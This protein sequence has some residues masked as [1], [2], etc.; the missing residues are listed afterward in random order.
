MGN[1]ITFATKYRPKKLTEY[2][3]NDRVINSLLATLR[4]NRPQVILIGG[5][6]G[7]GKTTLA[8][9]IAKEYL[10]EDRDEI[11]G[12][13]GECYNC[14]GISEY[15]ETGVNDKFLNVK[16]IDVSEAGKKQDIALL[17]ED[18]VIP[19]LT[20]EW[21]IYILDECHLMSQAAQSSLLKVIE[22]PPEKVLFILCT[23]EKNKMLDTIMSRCQCVFEI[24]KPKREDLL[25]MM[26][27]VAEGEKFKYSQNGFDL[28][29]NHSSFA[30]RK[31]LMTLQQVVSE[32][33]DATYNN[34]ISV[35]NV[36]ADKYY[37]DF[38]EL[39]LNKPI[40]L[41]RYIVLIGEL[42]RVVGLDIFIDGLTE[43]VKK[44]IYIVNGVLLEGLDKSEIQLISKL[45]K[46]FKVTELAW[47]LDF[48][49]NI[50]YRS[51]IETKLLLLGYTGV[52]DIAK[53]VVVEDK[54]EEKK[55]E[56]INIQ[57]EAEMIHENNEIKNKGTEK[58]IAEKIN[59][60]T[61]SLN[62]EELAET[63]G[64]VLVDD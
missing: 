23:T 54:Q 11:T 22:E 52:G 26:T 47:L 27:R 38:F 35:L 36:V 40:N 6:S 61:A 43:F 57:D 13:C 16:E 56:E 33:G 24:T 10:C 41:G 25:G 2:I 48:L 4:T 50:R 21:K 5:Q 63:F 18:A 20:G 29:I 55:K 49:V 19:S 53:S 31:V 58:E 32:K 46:R 17:L 44:G 3:G 7:C 42:K 8:R 34:V 12:A 28:I 51:D 64:G 9:L 60:L 30:P 62:I 37:F 15:I 59:D 14:K 1:T 45:F 39:L